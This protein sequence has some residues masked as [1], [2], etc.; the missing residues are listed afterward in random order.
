M[1][2][3][4]PGAGAQLA[5]LAEPIAA[6]AGP[7]SVASLR[8]TWSAQFDGTRDPDHSMSIFAGIFTFV[9]GSLGYPLLPMIV[10]A[11]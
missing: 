2:G 8:G 6:I 9:F 7:G 4:N 10:G 3:N 1:E 5:D 11:L